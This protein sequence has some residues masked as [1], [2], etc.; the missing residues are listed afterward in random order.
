MRGSAYKLPFDRSTKRRK[1][2]LPLAIIAFCIFTMC[3]YIIV[4]NLPGTINSD[5]SMAR[6]RLS[7]DDSILPVTS[8]NIKSETTT[9]GG[10]TA[11]TLVL[12]EKQ[13]SGSR[14]EFDENQLSI[15]REVLEEYSKLHTETLKRDAEEGRLTG[16]YLVLNPGAQLVNRLRALLSVLY[17]GIITSRVVLTDISRSYAP[18]LV[19]IFESP[20]F[21]WDITQLDPK[22]KGHFSNTR[23]LRGVSSSDLNVNN[24]AW[25]E[26]EKTIEKLVCEDLTRDS[27]SVINVNSMAFFWPLI[28]RNT[29]NLGSHPLVTAFPRTEEGI[30]SLLSILAKMVFRPTP[31]ISKR[32]SNL[33]AETRTKAQEY[34][35][36]NNLEKPPKIVG[37][38]VRTEYI[39]W[40]TKLRRGAELNPWIEL[41]GTCAEALLP[42]EKEL[43]FF[44]ATDMPSTQESAVEIWGDRVNFLPFTRTGATVG[45]IQDAVV[46]LLTVASF[47]QLVITPHSSF[48]ELASVLSPGPTY[49]SQMPHRSAIAITTQQSNRREVD[50]VYDYYTG[51]VNKLTDMCLVQRTAGLYYHGLWPALRKVSCFD[52][53]VPAFA[54]PET[55]AREK[56][57]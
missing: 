14:R 47:D 16:K 54:L 25:L 56:S 40:M 13:E 5:K 44:L 6:P 39:E 32:V 46:D 29:V 28:V 33:V 12:G 51:R 34:A 11:S 50:K 10:S 20:G 18:K 35:V 43:F 17:L 19:D 3:L 21:Q 45:G 9:V 23:G 7:K 15:V 52:E 55:T 30:E 27:T 26:N 4:I 37:L 24:L 2:R 8:K 49:P 36:K 57:R 31:G 1:Q 22:V 42:N 41:Y 53:K 38:Q 48:S